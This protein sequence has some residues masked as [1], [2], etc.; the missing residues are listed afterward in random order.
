MPTLL[1][2]KIGITGAVRVI[3]PLA[4]TGAACADGGRGTHQIFKTNTKTF[5]FVLG[6]W[7]TRRQTNSPTIQLDNLSMLFC[8]LVITVCACTFVTCTL[9]KINQ[10]IN[11]PTTNSRQTNSPTNQL[12]EID[13]MTFRLTAKC[14]GNYESSAHLLKRQI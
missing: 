14:N 11:S 5:I 2:R 3:R 9:I 6:L 4:P 1:A 7:T 13:I 10:S 8:H 12:A